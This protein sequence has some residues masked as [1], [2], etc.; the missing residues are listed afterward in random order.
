MVTVCIDGWNLALR[1]GSGIATYGHSLLS[2]I[3]GLGFNGQVLY[4][5]S[6]PRSSVNLLNEIALV[7]AGAPTRRRA[8]LGRAASTLAARFGR[9]AYPITPSGDV[10]WP[11]TGPRRPDAESYWASTDVFNLSQRAYQRYG[12]FTPVR[13]EESADHP[14]PD[15][16]HWTCPLPLTAPKSI[17]IVTFHDIIPL[18]LPGTTADNKRIFYN[19]CKTAID[20]ADHVIAVSNSTKR[21]MI[22]ILGAAPDKITTTF[23]AT[24]ATPQT[25]TDEDCAAS[26]QK[27]LGLEWKDYFL[28]FGAIEPKKNLGRI[29][30]AF[31]AANTKA[32]LVVVGGRSWLS[33]SETGLLEAV[34]ENDRSKKIVRLDYLP[35]STLRDLVRGAK[36]TVFPSLY[37]GFGLPV[38]ESMEAGT[39]VLTSDRGALPEVAGDAAITVDPYDVNSIRRAIQTMDNDNSLLENMAIKGRAQAKLFTQAK[40]QEKLTHAYKSAGVF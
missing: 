11:T 6:T 7:D 26:L 40:Y 17:N 27:Q 30:E 13:F 33:E 39:P 28:F 23:Q 21:D 4:G 1:K 37:E 5:P 12:I 31:L 38:L 20:R 2:A 35:S 9:S 14:A 8:S 32:R 16:M 10:I 19:L 24:P 3:R 29:V 36:A 22:E 15:V 18:R 25:G 34:L